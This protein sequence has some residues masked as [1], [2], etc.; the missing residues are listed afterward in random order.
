MHQGAQEDNRSRLWAFEFPLHDSR[1]EMTLH[2][3][4]IVV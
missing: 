2:G 3:T 1:W 4:F